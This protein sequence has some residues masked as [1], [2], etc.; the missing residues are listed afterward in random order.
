MIKE[1][2][3]GHPL[4]K[5]VINLGATDNPIDYDMQLERE[6]EEAFYNESNGQ[7]KERLDRA[8]EQRSVGNY[9]SQII[10]PMKKFQLLEKAMRDYPAGTNVLPCFSL[11]EKETTGIY[12]LGDEGVLCMTGNTQEDFYIFMYPEDWATVVPASI[13]SGK[14]AIQVTNQREFKLLMEHY[15]SKGWKNFSDLSAAYCLK[16]MWTAPSYA[17]SYENKWSSSRRK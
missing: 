2:N 6:Q 16:N 13:L 7:V 12:S 15:E 9:S 8:I 14:C 11:C 17:T 10:K 3:S 4:I 1:T 5:A